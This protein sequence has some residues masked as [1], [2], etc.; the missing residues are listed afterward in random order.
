MGFLGGSVVKYPPAIQE[1]QLQSLCQKDSLEESLATHSSIL[2]WRISQ[3]EE[4]AMLQSI[5]LQRV[6]HD[7]SDWAQAWKNRI[8]VTRSWGERRERYYLMG[9]E[10]SL[11]MM[12]FLSVDS[13][14]GNYLCYKIVHLQAVKMT[15]IML[16]IFHCSKATWTILKSEAWTC[17]CS[18]L[19]M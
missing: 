16:C 4:A 7:W 6:R 2:D 13:C 15:N 18:S 5:G 12:K 3:T 9:T 11:V 17:V 14:N 19:Q 8:Q 1:M 10:F